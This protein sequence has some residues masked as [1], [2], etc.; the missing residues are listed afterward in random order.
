MECDGF[1]ISFNRGEFYFDELGD[2]NFL[3][4]IESRDRRVAFAHLFL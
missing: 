3:I 1:F 4:C 2:Y